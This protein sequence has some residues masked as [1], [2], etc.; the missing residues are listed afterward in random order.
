MSEESSSS[1]KKEQ[2]T[3]LVVCVGTGGVFYHGLTLLSNFL[4]RREECGIVLI[5]GDTVEK[6]NE[7]RQ[8]GFG[9]GDPK[10]VCADKALELLTGSVM[11][12][13]VYNRML[14]EP[15]ELSDMV[16]ET[17]KELS[18]QQSIE[19]A[20]KRLFVLHAPD[21]HLCRVRTH[22]GCQKL[23]KIANKQVIEITGGNTSSNGYA[24]GCL[25][26]PTS[27]KG[28]FLVR[29]PDISLSA[30]NELRRIEHPLACGSLEIEDESQTLFRL[31]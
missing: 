18:E 9:V 4:K 12:G 31:Q 23:S 25:H 24:F 29:H 26:E 13:N 21:N 3:S 27:C 20:V 30:D 11:L 1:I 19:V 2:I 10:V 15:E 28:D 7:L 16:L 6:K 5:D 14:N 8:W 22:I 17:C